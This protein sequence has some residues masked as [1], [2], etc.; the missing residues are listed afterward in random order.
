MNWCLSHER[1]ATGPT[2]YAC[3]C[4]MALQAAQSRGLVAKDAADRAIV[5]LKKA[6][7]QGYGR[8]QGPTDP[9][10]FALHGHP[11]FTRLFHP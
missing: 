6:L 8:E 3:A 11:E 4:M 5:W 7:A 1:P 10:L 2:Q 9:D